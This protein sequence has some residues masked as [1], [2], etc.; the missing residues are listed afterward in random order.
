MKAVE[1]DGDR[2]D[3]ELWRELSEAGL[4]SLAVPE[5][6]GGAGLGL[7]ELCRVLV[8]VGRT[9][10]PVP[11]AVHGP[12]ALL[13]AELGNDEQ[14]DAWLPGAASGELVLTAAVAE[15]RSHLSRLGRRSRPRPTARAGCS[16]DPRRS[17]GPVPPRSS[18]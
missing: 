8:E 15:E 6:Y 7:T 10:A 17:C 3:R 18:C 9:V 11:L 1:K 5:A 14:K 4:L 13:L 12:A 2:F 16:A